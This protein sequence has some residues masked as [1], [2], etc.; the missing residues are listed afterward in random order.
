MEN[1][2]KALI[3]AGAILLSI[4]IIALGIYVFNLAKGSM[5]TSSLDELEISQFNQQY[6]TYRGRIM[7]STVVDLLDKL[8]AG[9]TTNKGAS[10]RLPDIVYQLSSGA[11]NT[12]S[13]TAEDSNISGMS[14]LRSSI[15][16][17]HYYYVDFVND[18]NSGLI[19]A[20]V[21]VYNENQ[22]NGAMETAKN[23]TVE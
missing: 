11:V 23:V 15:V 1:A 13:S 2:S 18:D 16:E 10:D 9:G 14:E 5:N 3:I 20:V 8:V 12:I 7:G 19:K 22:L 17:R 21:I 6:T 4:L